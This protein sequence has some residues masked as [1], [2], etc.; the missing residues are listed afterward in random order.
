MTD[1][2]PRRVKA[3]EIRDVLLSSVSAAPPQRGA[4]PGDIA[5]AIV[6]K[7]EK[8]WRQLMKPI[9]DE[10]I[11]LARDGKVVLMRKGKP[12]DPNRL[13][14]LYRIRLLAEG[15]TVPT[16]EPLPADDDL[17]DFDDDE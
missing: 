5:R 3:G 17:D 12:C 8:K 10:A 7:D 6:G 14:G 4:D 15:E 11:R 13:R 1:I 9:K 2:D 16:F